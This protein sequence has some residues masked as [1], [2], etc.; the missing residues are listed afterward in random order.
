MKQLAI[1]PAWKDVWICPDPHAGCRATFLHRPPGIR[2]LPVG[3]D[4]RWCTGPDRSFG[5]TRRPAA[6]AAGEGGAR[7]SQR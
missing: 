6:V 3:L 2:P 5:R 4:N 1:P 7:A